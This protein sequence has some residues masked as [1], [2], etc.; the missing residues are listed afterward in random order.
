MTNY[1]IKNCSGQFWTG[2]C[3]GVEQAAQDY[4]EDNLPDEV[5]GYEVL[6]ATL[7]IGDRVYINPEDQDNEYDCVSIVRGFAR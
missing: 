1:F 3:W 2:E 7:S 4:N 5:G 6:D